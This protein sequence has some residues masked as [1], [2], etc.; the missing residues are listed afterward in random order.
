[1][2][3][4]RCFLVEHAT[5]W[6]ITGEGSSGLTSTLRRD[7]SPSELGSGSLEIAVSHSG[8]NYKD[9]LALTGSRGVVRHTPLIPGIDAVGSVVSCSEGHYQPGDPVLLTGWGYGEQRHGGLATVLRADPQHVVALPAGLTAEQGATLGT[10]GFTAALAVAKLQGSGIT[11]ASSALPIAVTGAAGAVGSFCVFLL[12]QAGFVVTAITGRTDEEEYL[13]ALGA[14]DVISRQEVLSQAGKPLLAELYSA[15]IDQA[16]GELLATLLAST[17]SNGVVVA[18]GLAGGTHLPTTVMPF[19]LR[20]VSL[21]GINSVTQPAPLRREI[22]NQWAMVAPDVP[23]SEIATVI[24]MGEVA[25]YATRV[26]AG[27]TRGRVVV[28]VGA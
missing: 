16:G 1:M 9:A 23:W 7:I 14:R 18:C 15:V 3:Q 26:I 8:L 17:A 24:P 27:L 11:P 4:R 2:R 6:W 19:I 13:R 12:A 22:W 25:Q 10:A 28:S 20:G 21:M 5:G